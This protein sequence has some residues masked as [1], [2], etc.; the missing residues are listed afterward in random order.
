MLVLHAFAFYLKHKDI[1]GPGD[2][3]QG[4]SLWSFHGLNGL[5]GGNATHQWECKFFGWFRLNI[6]R[7]GKTSMDRLRL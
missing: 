7:T 5:S 4:D 6:P 2:I 1:F 3:A